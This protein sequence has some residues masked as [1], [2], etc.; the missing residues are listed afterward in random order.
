M[1]S[2][3]EERAM[4]RALE[5]ADEGLG[6]T[7]PN[8]SVGAVL[9]AGD[10]RILGEGH[11]QPP[12]GPH[13]EIAALGAAGPLARGATLVVTLEPCA[14]TGRT[15]PCTAA[16]AAAGVARVV[17]AMAD[18]LP[19]AAGGAATLQ[20]AGIE[21][22]AGVLRAEAERGA[23]AWLL[24]H[25]LHRPFVTLK[26]ATTV[27]GR[28]A[29]ADGTSK[30]ITSPEARADAHR[31]RSRVDAVL[32]GAGTVLADDPQLTAR[33]PDGAL[34]E[35]Q[36]LRVVLDTRGRV[37]RTARVHDGAA[38]TWVPTTA[39]LAVSASTG[40]FEPAAVLAGLYGRGVCH[41]LI[42][43]GPTLA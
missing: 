35:H 11:T 26:L 37:P 19:P 21:V 33:T 3:A 29:A 18:P 25:R 22:E 39:E 27:D 36:P 2:A 38:P 6:M 8:P 13:A 41:A 9:L 28:V 30:W 5:L 24:A 10:G 32:A 12:G 23:E 4:Q 7:S 15:A 16:I 1:A 34:R 42:E 43:G 31:W 17:Y 20:A 14:H 40:R